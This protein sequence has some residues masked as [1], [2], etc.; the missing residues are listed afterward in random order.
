MK[1]IQRILLM[2]SLTLC[3]GPDGVVI[4]NPDEQ[5]ITEHRES[6]RRRLKAETDLEQL[7]DLPAKR[8]MATL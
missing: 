1:R 5:V 4:I 6:E 2:A 8:S 3:A 7:Q